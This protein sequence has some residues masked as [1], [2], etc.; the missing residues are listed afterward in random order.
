MAFSFSRFSQKLS[1]K[2]LVALLASTGILACLAMAGLFS[3]SN[4]NVSHGQQRLIE[5]TKIQ[6]ATSGIELALIGLISRQADVFVATGTS[7]IDEL[8]SAEPMRGAFDN[9]LDTL[10]QV[11]NNDIKETIASTETAYASFVESDQRLL[12]TTVT[13]LTASEEIASRSQSIK[14][15]LDELSTQSD[16]LTG[17]LAFSVKRIKRRI[18]RSLK[19]QE[20]LDT[21]KNSKTKSPSTL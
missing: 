18:A 20:S 12:D 1:I 21:P 2:L 6:D 13:I 7:D 9:S 8:P 14:K 3:Y 4:S 11:D 5:T 19:K 16:A 10:R 17:K 15:Q